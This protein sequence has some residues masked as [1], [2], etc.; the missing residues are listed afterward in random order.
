MPKVL[1]LFYSRTGH[2]ARLADAIAEGA[3]QERFTEVDVR[4]IDDLAAPEVIASVPG[5]A[6]GRAALAGRYRTLE[7]VERL[8]DY[9]GI[10]LGSPAYH[11]AMA[12]ELK[13]VIDRADPL[14]RQGALA[15]RVGSAFSSAAAGSGGQ[16]T[17]TWSILTSMASLGMLLVPPAPV[18]ATIDNPLEAARELGRRVAKVTGWVRHAKGHEQGH[19]HGHHH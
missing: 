17:A 15:D 7:G 1:V 9:D 5:W 3:E 12:A 14:W 16:E 8:A 4:R 2:T 19:S 10:I 13:Q 18:T 6:E 11:G